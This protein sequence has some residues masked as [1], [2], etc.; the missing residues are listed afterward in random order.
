MTKLT[1]SR[2]L[3]TVCRA[4]RQIQG[5]DNG[6]KRSIEQAFEESPLRHYPEMKGVIMH[7]LADSSEDDPILLMANLEVGWEYY[8]SLPER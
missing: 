1:K 6:V 5:R 7:A 4:V 2:F 3:M 8:Q